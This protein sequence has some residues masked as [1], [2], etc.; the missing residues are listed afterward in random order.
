MSSTLTRFAPAQQ[1]LQRWRRSNTIGR[2]P[3]PACAICNEPVQLETSKTDENG[4]AVHG[5]CYV[6]KVRLMLTDPGQ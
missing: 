1:W 5:E 2:I 6:L 3:L 4:R